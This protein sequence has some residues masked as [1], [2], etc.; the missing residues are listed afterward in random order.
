MVLHSQ[1]PTSQMS[2][3]PL[4]AYGAIAGSS[5][6]RQ[7]RSRRQWGI[8][9]W[10]CAMP[11]WDAIWGCSLSRPM[12]WCSMSLQSTRHSLQMGLASLCPTMLPPTLK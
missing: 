10:P 12:L 11:G 8:Q 4:P 9:G 5:S 6:A 2:A 1:P 3:P 7:W